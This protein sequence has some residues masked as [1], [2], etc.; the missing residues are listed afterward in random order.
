MGGQRYGQTDNKLTDRQI[1]GQIYE[2]T[3][4]QICG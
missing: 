2:Q 1:D 4:R 3:N